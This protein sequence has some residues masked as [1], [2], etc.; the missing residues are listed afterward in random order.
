[1]KNIKRTLLIGFIWGLLF[2]LW[3]LN[4]FLYENWNFHLFSL[5]SWAFVYDEFLQGWVISSFSDWV[6][7]ITILIAVPVF[8]VFWRLFLKVKWHPLVVGNAKRFF[9]RFKG[10]QAKLVGKK[11]KLPKKQSRTEIRPRPLDRASARPVSKAKDV[12]ASVAEN[13]GMGRSEDKGQSLA[14]PFSGGGMS[15][16][17]EGMSTTLSKKTSSGTPKSS[18]VPP[19][20]ADD[21]FEK[22]N[23]DDIK[24]PERVK[25]SEDIP[26]LF[27]KAGYKVIKDVLLEETRVDYVAVD[28]HQVI[29]CWLDGEKGDWLADEERFNGEDPLWFSESSHRISPVFKLNMI[30]K[31]LRERLE[32]SGLSFSVIPMLVEKEGN[33]IN[34]EDMMATWKEMKV[35]VARTDLGGPDELPTVTQSVPKTTGPISVEELEMVRSLF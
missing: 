32:K 4:G 22:I 15:A 12:K 24:L 19:F 5:D 16:F 9:Y 6:F 29:C 17:T 18:S 11:V 14:S 25:L 8:L 10:G 34:A 3:W 27:M 21:D 23:L 31:P 7:F 1:M 2:F 20:L 13:S 35:I 30:V 26:A 28:T 33:I